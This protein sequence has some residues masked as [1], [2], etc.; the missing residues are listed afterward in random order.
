M[1]PPRSFKMYKTLGWS[2]KRAA[3]CFITETEA[4]TG[5]HEFETMEETVIISVYLLVSR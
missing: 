3:T 1:R 2:E 5:A 4:G